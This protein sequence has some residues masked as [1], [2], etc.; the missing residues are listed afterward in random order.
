MVLLADEIYDIEVRVDQSDVEAADKALEALKRKYGKGIEIELDVDADDIRDLETQLKKLDDSKVDVDVD[1]DD[2]ELDTVES[3]IKK[4]DESEID[5]EVDVDDRELEEVESDIRQ[6]DGEQIDT[7]INT[8]DTALQSVK[9]E[10]NKLD[11]KT[12]TIEVKTTAQ[13]L[14]DVF[15]SIG[16]ATNIMSASLQN[17]GNNLHLLAGY[18]ALAS[19]QIASFGYEQASQLVTLGFENAKSV[20][21]AEYMIRAQGVTDDKLNNIMADIR[22]FALRSPFSTA[23]MADTVSAINAYTGD[24][25]MATEATKAFGISIMASGG[26]ASDLLRVGKNLGQLYSGQYNKTDYN[27]LIRGVPAMSQALRDMGVYTWDEFKETADTYDNTLEFILEA[28]T[29]YNEK[30][31]AF[32]LSQQS[33]NARI[34]NTQEGIEDLLGQTF[35]S[36]GL[37][38]SVGNFIDNLGDVFEQNTPVIEEFYSML[39]TGLDKVTEL[40]VNFDFSAFFQ[41][42]KTGFAE[43]KNE[44]MSFLGILSPVTD[45]LTGGQG[46]TAE[47]I[48]MAIPRIFG[49]TGKAYIGGSMFKGIASALSFVSTTST[50]LGTIFGFI[51]KRQGKQFA[52]IP[53]DTLESYKKMS[54]LRG[55]EGGGL[56]SSFGNLAQGLPT[57]G[58]NAWLLT[59]T[60]KQFSD[61]PPVHEIISGVAKI[62]SVQLIFDAFNTLGGKMRSMAGLNVQDQ[63]GTLLS[64]GSLFMLTEVTQRIANLQIPS[65]FNDKLLELSKVMAALTGFNLASTGVSAIGASFG[66]DKWTT[67]IGEIGA[68]VSAFASVKL[69]EKISALEIPDDYDDKFGKFIGVT[70]SLA[71]IN[72]ASTAISAIGTAFNVNPLHRLLTDISSIV[73]LFATT[74]VLEQLTTMDFPDDMDS[75]L[76]ALN[77]TITAMAYM[78]IPS[79]AVGAI[80]AINPIAGIVTAISDLTSS[81]SFWVM[82]QSL[83][84]LSEIPDN[85]GELMGKLGVLLSAT[86][87]IAAINLGR[88]AMAVSTFGISALAEMI[89]A[90]STM[91]SSGALASLAIATKQLA[92]LPDE[93]TIR[94][95]MNKLSVVS[96]TI[97]TLNFDGFE[98]NFF[99]DFGTRL[100]AWNQSAYTGSMANVLKNLSDMT[101]FFETVAEVDESVYEDG[102]EKLEKISEVLATVKTTLNSA[103]FGNFFTGLNIS[104][105]ADQISQM[106]EIVTMLEEFEALLQTIDTSIDTV[107]FDDLMVRFETMIENIGELGDLITGDNGYFST[108]MKNFSVGNQGENYRVVKESLE[109][110]TDIIEEMNKLNTLLPESDFDSSTIT[111]TA[112]QIR[113]FVNELNDAFKQADDGAYNQNIGELNMHMVTYM[114]GLT[115]IADF[116]SKLSGIVDEFNNMSTL[117]G[118]VGKDML[119][120]IRESITNV[121]EEM[122]TL[123]TELSGSAD[124]FSPEGLGELEQIAQMADYLGQ[125]S[126]NVKKME[127]ALRTLQE[128][129][130]YLA[131]DKIAK[132]AVTV[133]ESMINVMEEIKTMQ[134]EISNNLESS[135]AEDQTLDEFIE[136]LNDFIGKIQTIVTSV[137]TMADTLVTLQE[138]ELM[139]EEVKT[140]MENLVKSIEE[141]IQS[142]TSEELATALASLG[143]GG[144]DGVN[145]AIEQINA[146]VQSVQQAFDDIG[147]L[148]ESTAQPTGTNLAESL[149]T[150]FTSADFTPM[151]T[152][153]TEI[154]DEIV[155]IGTEKINSLQSNVSSAFSTMASNAVASIQ[156]IIDKLATIPEQINV[157]VNVSSNA[158]SVLSEIANL[159]AYASTPVRVARAMHGGLV[160]YGAMGRNNRGVQYFSKGGL[161][162]MNPYVSQEKGTDKIPAMLSNREFVMNRKATSFW[163]VPLLN[164]LN[165]M[166]LDRTRNLIGNKLGEMTRNNVVYNYTTTTVNQTFNSNASNQY[167]GLRRLVRGV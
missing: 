14:A 113:D 96:S 36:S 72:L 92:D 18:G 166:N 35:K 11:G 5:V 165:N 80:S 155:R 26:N 91:M 98:G 63:L 142:L 57:L 34:E 56:G 122:K 93:N 78:K 120:P 107:D 87:G 65:N 144:T 115:N 143:D 44:F 90:L 46:L 22:D 88:G 75:R 45:Y 94:D 105:S 101:G 106:N 159:R 125:I 31:D 137:G 74:K 55:L 33:L 6:L 108:I 76:D 167:L 82:V 141:I 129:D 27:E 132:T 50:L 40:M 84:G 19:R 20:E 37:Y 24:I 146:F 103:G 163:G 156:E 70:T 136:Y 71:T 140:A 39:A 124:G 28:I 48:G 1:V 118:V 99:Q 13:Q 4:L 148:A 43:L 51:G 42:M 161:V 157:S 9:E 41:S 123:Q 66:V 83:K 97:S 79:I 8:N 67:L 117:Q 2:S 102:G 131:T 10:V 151:T 162:T 73:Q 104:W 100:E 138:T 134:T 114:E 149:V 147:A 54:S 86:A 128:G 119:T 150:G 154:F 145:Q 130:G 110:M 58:M 126:D 164:A 127:D 139:V 158:Q 49:L 111:D 16:S 64:T 29:K 60:V 52:T 15:T 112:E 77:K 69:I 47:G 17:V 12:V 135:L 152:K 68:I 21:Q 7:T 121:I 53:S 3:D 133:R 32:R 153:I 38:D 25:D 59:Q 61:L 95:G 23:S 89:G 85:V 160:A 30:T 109:Q 116:I 81:A 62:A